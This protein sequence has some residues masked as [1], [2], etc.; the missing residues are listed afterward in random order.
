MYNRAER[1]RKYKR[2]YLP[3]LNLTRAMGL[4]KVGW[5]KRLILLMYSSMN[6]DISYTASGE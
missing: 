6:T 5:A 2:N 4:S 3:C 1:S